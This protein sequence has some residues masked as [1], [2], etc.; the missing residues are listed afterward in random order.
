MKGFILLFLVGLQLNVIANSDSSAGYSS[1]NPR[2]RMA[3][4][5]DMN[6]MNVTG[7]TGFRGVGVNA[8]AQVDYRLGRNAILGVYGG[9]ASDIS[10]KERYFQI[11]SRAYDLT[12]SKL[13]FFGVSGG[14]TV[15]REGRFSVTP[16][17]RLGLGYFSV[18]EIFGSLNSNNSL[19][20]TILMI[21]P[22]VN[23]G[24]LVG[25]HFEPGINFSYLIPHSLNGDISQYD[26]G[27]VNAGVFFKFYF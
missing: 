2:G 5:L 6:F 20:R 11:E 25:K 22:R 3:V 15:W 1:M 23:F 12:T 7:R 8:S 10:T 13:G 24:F 9:Y 19:K 16:D 21:T 27:N 14:Y 4:R 26:L 18:S 17:V